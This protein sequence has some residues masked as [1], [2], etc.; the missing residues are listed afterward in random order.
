M[1][2]NLS[3]GFKAPSLYQLYGQY[4]ANP[5][6]KPER[7]FSSEIG[8]QWLSQDKKIE[9]RL[10]A[11]TRS[12]KDVIVYAYPTNINL[13][14]QNDQGVELESTFTLST[15]L[16]A[17]AFYSFVDGNVKT[18]L[19]GKDTTFNNLFRRPK[20]MVG[21]NLGYQINPQTYVSINSKFFGQRSDL[22]FDMETFTN[23]TV[24]LQAYTLLDFYAEYRLKKRKATFFADIKN[25]L[26]TD[27]QEV[28]G[29][30][31][32]G[33]NINTGINVRF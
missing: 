16:N 20:H 3:T 6:L 29:Y 2:F 9:L 17:K 33:L 18:Q 15:K 25:I 11:F 30:S 31:T 23:Q 10:V 22:Y 5:Q 21:I 4:G 14:K 7:S 8:S 32:M 13:D 26:N 12:I 28:Y 1:F 27:Y 24:S 19:L